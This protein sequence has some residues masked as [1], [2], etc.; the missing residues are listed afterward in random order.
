M[1][2]N[3][4][5]KLVIASTSGTS[6]EIISLNDLNDPQGLEDKN[7]LYEKVWGKMPPEGTIT[8]RVNP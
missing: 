5:C 1:T 8:S 6:L 7:L 3:E 2:S 4:M